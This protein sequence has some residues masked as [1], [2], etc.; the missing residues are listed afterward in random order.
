M[1]G[2]DVKQPRENVSSGR[3][4]RR[5]CRVYYATVTVAREDLP[6]DP[7]GLTRST[8][9]SFGSRSREGKYRMTEHDV[10]DAFRRWGYLAARLDD[11]GRLEPFEHPDLPGAS[12]QD[13]ERWRRVYCGSIGAEFMHIRDVERASWVADAMETEPDPA[14]RRR[15][16]RRLA[17]AEIFERFVHKRY[18][19]TKRYSLEGS[20]TLITLL[21]SIL[22]AAGSRGTSRCLIGMSHRGRLNVLVN[23]VGRPASAL[24]TH[25]E[26]PD[27]RS[28]L[29]SGDVRYHLGATGVY[30]TVTGE[31]CAIHLVSN[32][33]H[34]EAVD[35][36]LM[37]RARARQDRIGTRGSEQ[38]LPVAIHG[39]AAFAGQGIAAETLNMDGLD[40]FGVGGT[41]QI[42]VDNLIGFTADPRSLHASRFA[43]DVAKRLDVPILHVNGEDPEAVARVGRIAADYRSRFGE[44]VVV[45]LIGYRRYGHSEVDDPT[46]THP[47]L[48]R[49]IAERPMLWQTYGERIDA[50]AAELQELEGEIVDRL[51]RELE[52]GRQRRDVPTFR[53][54]PA[55]WKPYRGGGWDR[56][57][58]VDT[59]VERQVLLS[60]AERLASAP[61]GFSVHP[62]V[63]RGLEQRRLMGRGERAIDWGMAEALAFGSLLREGVRVRLT[64]QDTRRGTFNHRHSILVDMENGEEYCPLQHVDPDQVPFAVHD[65]VLSEAAALGFEYGY[66]RDFPDALVCWEAQFGDFA[67][68]AQVIVDQFVSA[69]EDKWQLLSGLVLLLPHGYEGQGPEHSSAR[70]ERFL[71][72]AAEDNIQI[73]QPSCACQYFHLLRRQALRVWRKP[74]VVLT[75]KGQLRSAMTASPLERLESGRFRPVLSDE[76]VQAAE[77]VLVCSGKIACELVDAREQRRRTRTAIVRVEQLYPFPDSELREALE[78]YPEAE[79]L[80]VQEEPG[81]MGA[82]SFVRPRLQAMIGK[83]YVKAVKRSDSASPATGSSKAHKLEQDALLNLALSP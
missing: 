68:G 42:V 3:Y 55:Y 41:I 74:L 21:D 69:G 62:K 72:L 37:G 47:V 76:S 20:A 40:G 4:A 82:L 38:V 65:S 8:A 45:D 64:G 32:A 22:N 60:I 36:V 77:R 23:V 34:L 52:A 18:V 80:W 70:L 51:R 13:T 50:E 48:Y 24:F 14:D 59:G 81:N 53:E 75:P 33:S 27:P 26:E 31:T 83:R 9:R 49:R 11:L 25:F 16:L 58:E 39:D 63:A 56:S 43:S 7:L 67:N 44:D 30:R 6:E 73:C 35:P 5:I 10:R 17:E 54:L 78:P 61:A 79:V 66:S 15:L 46:T 1:L 2:I 19:G 12:G 71:Q 28:V 29:G 57:M